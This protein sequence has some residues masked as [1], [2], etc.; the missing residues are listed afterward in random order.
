MCSCSTNRQ[1][2]WTSP[3]KTSILTF[4]RD[5]N[6]TRGVTILIVTHLLSLALDFATSVMLMGADEILCGPVDEV[7]TEDRLTALYGSPI[8]LGRVGGQRILVVR[9]DAPDV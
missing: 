2:G 5:L 6:R 1:P 9:R 7:L 8:Q 3:A 4:L